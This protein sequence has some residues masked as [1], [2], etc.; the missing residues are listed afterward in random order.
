MNKFVFFMAVALLLSACQTKIPYKVEDIPNDFAGLPPLPADSGFQL[1]IAPFPIPPQFEREVFIRKD[2]HNND[3]IYVSKIRSYSRSGTHHFVLST[4][5]ED[6]DFPLPPVDV[7]MD[8]N[9]IDGTFNLF[10]Q[11]NRDF[12]LFEAQ[13]ADYTLEM[14]K[15]Y[16][17]RMSKDAKLLCNPHY[18]NKT[19][20]V[21]FGEVYCNLY[22]L[23]KDSV[24]QILDNDLIDG[25]E[26]LILP[27]GK[28]TTITTDRIFDKKTQIVIATPHYH[29]RGQKFE[30]QIIGG[31]R[32]G[33]TIIQSY[34][35][36]HPVVANFV[37]SPLILEAGEGLKTIVTYKNESNHTVSYGV[38]S[39]DE[40][41]YL[42]FYYFNP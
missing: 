4:L 9:N 15:G 1:H 23:P 21:R 8:Q 7:M 38:T 26:K 5:Y 39:E 42:F 35:Y 40:M 14:P 25:N 20:N 18:F 17:L 12:I 34:D 31:A 3:E 41:N 19:D 28:E 29:K 27:A 11:V 6:K 16:G 33:E 30:V 24:K 2:L 36:Q 10:S 13:S 32:N 22:T 37:N